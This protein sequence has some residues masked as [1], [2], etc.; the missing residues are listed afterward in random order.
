M[1]ANGWLQFGIFTLLLVAS[2]RPVGS[3][4]VV[5]FEGKRSW[6]SPVLKPVEG[7]FY[8]LCGVDDESEMTWR[9]YAK[10][11]LGFSLVSLLLT[12]LIERLQAVLPMNPQKLPAVETALA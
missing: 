9:Q 7:L 1:T 11:I 6:L 2:V 3:Y 5:V 8:K 4:L 12:Y 10:A